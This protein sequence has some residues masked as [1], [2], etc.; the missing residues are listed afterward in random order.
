MKPL[1]AV[2]ILVL[3]IFHINV[4]SAYSDKAALGARLIRSLI[5]PKPKADEKTDGNKQKD[6]LSKEMKKQMKRIDA[7]EDIFIGSSG[8]PGTKKIVKVK[9]IMIML[10]FNNSRH[11]ACLYSKSSLTLT[12]K[13]W[14]F[15][16]SFS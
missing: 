4:S 1:L 3:G 2:S 13:E 16:L 6:T 7:L 11:I 15:N 8:S 12:L 5:K 14:R 9:R 10:N